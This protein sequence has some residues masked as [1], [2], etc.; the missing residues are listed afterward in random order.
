MLTSKTFKIAKFDGIDI[1]LDLSFIIYVGILLLFA[2][3]FGL[4]ILAVYFCVFLHELGHVY[5]FRKI[6]NIDCDNIVMTFLGGMAELK[7]PDYNYL[8]EF[9]KYLDKNPKIELFGTLSGPFVNFLIAIVLFGCYLISNDPTTFLFVKIN[10][11]LGIFNFLPAYPMDGGRV[12][13]SICSIYK[14]NKFTI[15]NISLAGSILAG[16]IMITW[17]VISFNI[18]LIIIALILV[19]PGAIVNYRRV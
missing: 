13:K 10:L 17:G 8:E 15:R 18:M 19:I 16:L 12:L 7:H 4:L 1:H 2:H 14:V 9:E 6:S 11:M 3:S 5:A